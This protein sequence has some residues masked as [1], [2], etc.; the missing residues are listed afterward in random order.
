[1]RWSTIALASI[2]MGIVL[3][4]PMNSLGQEE[5]DS[6]N[7]EIALEPTVVPEQATI[8]A[9]EGGVVVAASGGEP[10][11]GTI[12]ES[13][14][15]AVADGGEVK[16]GLTG[17]SSGSAVSEPV[18]EGPELLP[19]EERPP[20]T[21]AAIAAEPAPIQAEI[22]TSAPVSSAAVI[23]A[24][25]HAPAA[26]SGGRSDVIAQG[27][28]D[29]ATDEVVW[30]TVRYE[31][32]PSVE[33][34]IVERPLGFVVA[35]EDSLVLVDPLNGER[36]PLARG[37]AAFVPA[38][39]GQQRTSPFDVS[40][41]YLAIELVAAA[42]ADEI[43]NGAVLHVSEPF[44]P[45]ASRRALV[46]SRHELPAGRV[47]VVPDTSERNLLTVIE[48]AVMARAS[49][50]SGGAS[51]IAGES[52][53]FRGAWE[54]AA[55]EVETAKGSSQNPPIILIASMGAG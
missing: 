26:P 48:G 13:P 40:V 25:V 27:V 41:H 11:V 9:A 3:G 37:E 43:V 51:L 17:E 49:G 54:V 35:L 42:S 34:P 24:V 5:T 10:I 1:M 19:P 23:P 31:A 12:G 33:S 29:I 14:D 36:T 47:L 7:V 6:T 55:A 18:G 53:A 2:G 30:R 16:A 15:P 4:S 50:A 22:P 32:D 38:N 8:S 39:A 46:L 28:V 44:A 20:L 21:E 52:I 45:A